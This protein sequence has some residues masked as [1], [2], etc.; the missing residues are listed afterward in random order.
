MTTLTPAAQEIYQ[1]DHERRMAWSL[2]GALLLALTLAKSMGQIPVVTSAAFTVIALAQLYIPLWRCDRLG[3]SGAFVGLHG[4]EWRRDLKLTMILCAVIFPP[5][6]V[7]HHVYMTRMHGWAVAWDLPA[8][9]ALL[10]QAVWQPHMPGDLAEATHVGW[11]ALQAIA[12]HTLGIA[13]PEETFYRGYLQTQ[14]E[15][16]FVPHRQ[17]LGV[18]IGMGAVITAALFALGHFLG[19][20]DPMRLGP[21]IPAL[22]FAWQRNATQ[23]IWGAVAFH[24]GCNLYT[25]ALFQMYRPL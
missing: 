1:P 4:A 21:F 13:L 14:L 18:R 23:S 5:Y 6:A 25:S 15:T 16:K 11:L 9:A 20:W 2:T 10:P 17:I 3:M 19:E 12:T 7:I 24:A 22:I 8:L